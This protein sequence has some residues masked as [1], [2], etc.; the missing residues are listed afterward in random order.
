[1]IPESLL[2]LIDTDTVAGFGEIDPDNVTDDPAAIEFEDGFK[3]MLVDWTN[4][5][6]TVTGLLGIENWQGLLDGLTEH[7]APVTVQ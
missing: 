7:D 2:K 5:A 4:A 6:M 3:V 1:M